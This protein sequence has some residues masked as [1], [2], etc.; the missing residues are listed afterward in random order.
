MVEIKQSA[1]YAVGIV[2]M[3]GLSLFMIPYITHTLSIT[4]YGSLEALVLLADIG[5]ILFSLGLI[6]A[7]YRYVGIAKGKERQNLIS[8]CFTL[9]VL[10]CVV[11]AALLLLCLP[12]LLVVLPVKFEAYQIAMLLIPTMLDGAISIPLTLMR[13]EALAKRFCQLTVLKAIIQ[14]LLTVI[15]LEMGY[16]IDGILFS[17]AISS[18]V[19]LIC[20]MPYQ[21][22][23]MGSFGYLGYSKKLLYFALPT[24]VGFASIYMLS[25]LDKWFMASLVGVEEL[26]IYAVAAKFALI[27]GL[28]IQPYSLWW[29]PNRVATLKQVGG[30][31]IC[32]D[33]A[34]LG[35]NIGVCIGTIMIL[36]IP[37]FI[38]LAL[39]QEYENAGVIAISLIA[40]YM[41]K[42]AGDMMNLGCYSGDSSQSQMWIQCSSAALAVLGYFVLAPIFGLWGII[43]VLGSAYLLRL[44]LF[45][46]VSQALEK[47]P[48]RHIQWILSVSIAVT[49][50]LAHQCMMLLFPQL[51]HFILGISISVIASLMFVKYSVIPIPQAIL[52]KLKLTWLVRSNRYP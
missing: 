1:Y 32:A 35:V 51:S 37:G 5:T 48:Y 17:S 29:F 25:G 22:Q 12:I 7:I 8:N 49:A 33:R 3:K 39:P 26:A 21:Y 13:M 43:F 2:M 18:V 45:F 42:N 28:A 14:A 30:K 38:S 16:G 23:S 27:L 34:I 44:I 40:I 19:L 20:L 50:I 31:S 24:L 46:N 4:E 11:G 9:S 10:A 15:F 41:I 6:D 36:T 47:L 52:T